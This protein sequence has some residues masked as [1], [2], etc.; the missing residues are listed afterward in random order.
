MISW[1]KMQYTALMIE[2]AMPY[3]VDLHLAT[4]FNRVL[5]RDYSCRYCNSFL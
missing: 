3:L 1:L 5:W 2:F 4:L